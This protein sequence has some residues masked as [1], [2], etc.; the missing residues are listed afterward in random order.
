MNVIQNIYIYK[1]EFNQ[2]KLV[3]NNYNS[4]SCNSIKLNQKIVIKNIKE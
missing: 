2:F 4:N 3:T 1:K